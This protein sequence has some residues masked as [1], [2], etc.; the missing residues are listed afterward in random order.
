M[1]IYAGSIPFKIKEKELNE[2][3]SQFGEVASVKIIL[4]NIT[5]QNKGFAFIVMP[6]DEE[7]LLAI[8]ALDGTELM[9]RK[10]MVSVSEEKKMSGVK[11]KNWGK[12]GTNLKGSFN[13]R[14]GNR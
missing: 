11:K 5:R 14:T 2:I 1:D 8:K 4:D 13:K 7:A 9:G 10:I 6:N 3:F 12:G